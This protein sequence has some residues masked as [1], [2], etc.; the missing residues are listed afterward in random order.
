MVS[1][2]EYNI[3]ND[4]VG[5]RL[6]AF[7]VEMEP[8]QTRSHFKNLILEGKILVNNKVVKSGYA[9]KQG[10]VVSVE[11][12]EAEPMTAKP[13]DIPLDILYQDKDFAIINK[14][15]GMVVH[16]AVKNFDNTLVNA[17]LFNISDLSGINGVLRPGIVHRLDKDTSGLIVVAK[18]D[19]AHANLSKQISEK[20]CRRIY[21]GIIEGHLKESQGVVT[22]YIERSKKNR[23][24]MAVSDK[25]KFAETHYKVLASL[26]EFDLVRFELKTGR[27]HQIRVH[28]ENLHHPLLGDKLYGAKKEKY[29]KF[30]QF[31]HAYKLELTHPST[32]EKKQFT[33]LPPKYFMDILCVLD[34]NFDLNHFL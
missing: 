31:L 33:C 25:G 6:D 26:G 2:L 13:Q 1:T 22:S 21:L 8:K 20:T 34:K 4:N 14:P 10:D 32:N 3:T 12:I 27:T 5:K 17:L 24:K 30:G 19:F 29:Y 16:P 9:L 15:K 23:L 28:C 18:N 7:L 11:K